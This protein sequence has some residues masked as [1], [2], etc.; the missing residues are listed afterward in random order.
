MRRRVRAVV[1]S[2]RLRQGL[3]AEPLRELAADWPDDTVVGQDR[4]PP[5]PSPNPHAGG[6]PEVLLSRT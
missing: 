6:N 1:R 4:L 5:T 3:Q 2:R